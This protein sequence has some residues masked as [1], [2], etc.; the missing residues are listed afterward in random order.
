M[1]KLLLLCAMYAAM[2]AFATEGALSGLFSVS[3][4][5]QV[6]FSKGNLQIWRV[7]GTQDMEWR[8]AVNQYDTLGY[9]IFDHAIWME[10]D[11]GDWRDD[12]YDK[13]DTWDLFGWGTSLAWYDP[14]DYYSNYFPLPD[15]CWYPWQVSKDIN[16]YGN[17]NHDIAGTDRDWGV[18]NKIA[19]GGNEAGLWRTL[20]ANEW[21]YLFCERP[22]AANLFN[23]ATVNG[24]P[25]I[26]VL[27]DNWQLPQDL[28]FHSSREKGL[29]AEVS[30]YTNTGWSPKDSL[31]VDAYKFNTYS[32]QDWT[33]MENAGAVF[34]PAAGIREG[35]EIT[36]EGEYNVGALGFYW[37]STC[38]SNNDA[39]LLIFGNESLKTQ[40]EYSKYSGCSVRLVQDAPKQTTGVENVQGDDVQCTKVLRDGQLYLMYKG[41]MYNVQGTQIR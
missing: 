12:C 17:N 2:T 5:K 14:Y 26:I 19:N 1:R 30:N 36:I 21:K 24:I 37:S 7:G 41:T 4:T 34:L 11:P 22:S 23:Y 18:Y 16:D 9:S 13:D 39:Y 20:T 29:R 28:S 15:N 10:N 32:G 25:G 6:Y 27:P 35:E 33:K 8:F 31:N 38:S 3:S 40:V